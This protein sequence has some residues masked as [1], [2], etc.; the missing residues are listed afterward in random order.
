MLFFLLT[1]DVILMLFDAGLQYLSFDE[2]LD[3]RLCHVT[4]GYLLYEDVSTS[5]AALKP[6][7]S[8]VISIL[9]LL[10]GIFSFYYVINNHDK[11]VK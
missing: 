10:L 5:F 4:I 3:Q 8:A 7:V 11:R 6:V 2:I 9:L 1:I